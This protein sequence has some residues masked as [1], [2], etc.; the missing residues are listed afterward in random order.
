MIRPGKPSTGPYDDIIRQ[1]MSQQGDDSVTDWMIN[2]PN[3]STNVPLTRDVLRQ[4]IPAQTHMPM[5]Q[6]QEQ[7][8]QE[9]VRRMREQ[10]QQPARVQD[11]QWPKW[12]E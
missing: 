11:P 1:V 4:D 3:A 5:E 12:P 8:I 2:R 7:M 10:G 9:W 6:V